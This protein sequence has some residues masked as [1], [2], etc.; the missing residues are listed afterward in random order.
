VKFDIT[1]DPS[2]DQRIIE[3]TI[4]VGGQ[5]IKSK[6][7]NMMPSRIYNY[8]PYA[9]FDDKIKEKCNLMLKHI[10]DVWA[11]GNKKVYDY[12]INWLSCTAVGRKVRTYLYL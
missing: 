5:R 1:I 4:R 8:S 12:I 7:I 6:Y 2:S 11:N 9:D 3:K 10:H